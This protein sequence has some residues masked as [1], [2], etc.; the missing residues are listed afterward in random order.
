MGSRK[1]VRKETGGEEGGDLGLLCKIN[2]K[3]IIKKINDIPSK[4]YDTE[5][6]TKPFPF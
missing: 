4:H 2:F 6:Y 5:L 1:E 3:K